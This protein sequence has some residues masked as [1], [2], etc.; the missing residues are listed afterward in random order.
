MVAFPLKK[1]FGTTF[2]VTLSHHSAFEGFERHTELPYLHLSLGVDNEMVWAEW[3]KAGKGYVLH[4]AAYAANNMEEI[5]KHFFGDSL[6]IEDAAWRFEMDSP[7]Q[8]HQQT[9]NAHLLV[10]HKDLFG[11]GGFVRQCV[12]S[13]LKPELLINDAI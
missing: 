8:E 13:A 5:V 4:A 6:S 9:P 10:G 2:I 7:S 1:F 12:S 11:E 3:D